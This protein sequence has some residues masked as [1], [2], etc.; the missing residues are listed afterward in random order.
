LGLIAWA[1]VGLWTTPEVENALGLA[2]TKQDQ[3]ELER[4]LAVKV[5][6]V[7]KGEK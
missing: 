4:K 1:S 7:E 2:P 3:E 6:S 5:S